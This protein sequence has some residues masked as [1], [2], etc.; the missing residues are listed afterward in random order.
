MI[1]NQCL[2]GVAKPRKKPTKIV[3]FGVRQ[4][5]TRVPY[6]VKC[7]WMGKELQPITNTKDLGMT[8]DTRM[9][10]D[11]HVTN[12]L[13]SCMNVL[14]QINIIPIYSTAKY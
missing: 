7:T 2:S 13:S 1:F 12:V 4:L 5:L 6:D 10:Y 9:D 14:F 3:L 11:N 8:S